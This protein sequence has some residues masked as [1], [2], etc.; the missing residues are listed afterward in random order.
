[1]LH[2]ITESAELT[3]GFI[4]QDCPNTLHLVTELA[5]LNAGV[6]GQYCTIKPASSSASVN[7]GSKI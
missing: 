1:M 7:R 3:A 6:L 5:E 4:V 2:L